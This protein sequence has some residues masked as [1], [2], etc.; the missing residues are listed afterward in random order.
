MTSRLPPPPHIE[1]YD[2][3]EESTPVDYRCPLCGELQD[4]LTDEREPPDKADEAWRY[5]HCVRVPSSRWY[6][7]RTRGAMRLKGND[8]TVSFDRRAAPRKDRP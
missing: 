5:T 8:F 6:F 4:E 7:C 2:F 3:T 1:R